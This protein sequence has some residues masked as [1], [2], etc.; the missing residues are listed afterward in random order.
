MKRVLTALLASVALAGV[1]ALPPVTRAQGR[2]NSSATKQRKTKAEGRTK[3][4][5]AIVSLQAAKAELERGESDFG[6]YKKDAI[7]AVD[8]ALKQ[9]RLALQFEKY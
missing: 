8:N 4:H 6:G 5:A 2:R 7:E 9:L 1:L 3:I